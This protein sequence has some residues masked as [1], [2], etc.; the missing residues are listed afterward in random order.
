MRRLI[1]L[2]VACLLAP[3]A[4]AHEGHGHVIGWTLSGEVVLPLMA[5]LL[6]YLGG[7]TRLLK[8]SHHARAVALRRSALFL[9]GWFIL[10]GA[11]I[12]PLHEAG[13]VSFA[14]HMVEHELIMLPAALLLVAARPGPVLLWGLPAPGRQ[15]IGTVARMSLWRQLGNPFTATALQSAALVIWHMPALFDRAITFEVWHVAQ[16]LCFIVTALLFWWVM[17]PRGHGRAGDLV[18]ALCLFVTSMIG[19]GVGALMALDQSPW[20]EAYV[21]MGMTP[22]GLTPAEDQQ[23]AG[24]IMWIP[25]GLVHGAAALIVLGRAIGSA[26]EGLDHGVARRGKAG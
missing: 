19:G 2:A 11:L 3:P 9:S 20:Y 6:L 5:V 15:F 13:E 8:R 18:S 24:L 16:H 25:G 10:A 26:P 7:L 4:S 17:L 23:L 22:F 14:L 21:A 12:S 1:P